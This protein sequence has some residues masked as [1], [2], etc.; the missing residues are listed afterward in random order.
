MDMADENLTSPLHAD[1]PMNTEDTINLQNQAPPKTLTGILFDMQRH[2]T[3]DGP[4]IRTTLFFKGCNLRCRWCHNPESFSMGPDLEL[5]PRRCI[6]CGLCLAQCPNGAISAPNPDPV[7]ERMPQ[8]D[9][10]RCLACGSCVNFC[11]AGARV[12]AGKRYGVE[13][14]MQVV[15][16]D[17]AFYVNSGGGVTCS[18]GEPLLQPAFLISILKALREAGIHTAVDTA[19][20]VPWDVFSRILPYSDLILYDVKTVDDSIHREATGVGNERIMDNLRRLCAA[21]MPLWVR[22]PVIPG[23]NASD[24]EMS[25]I[26]MFLKECG[27]AGKVELLPLHHLGSG[28]YESL[29]VQWPMSDVK[30]PTDEE[31]TR[32]RGLFE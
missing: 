13:E 17:R 29:G 1:N 30:T 19:G 18:G 16:Q 24:A 22:I 21:G 15:L 3:H 4:G 10:E 31:M 14:V 2:T 7:S 8:T 23:V 27:H 28:K 12:L 20:N 9:R 32:W 5:Y 11:F 26:A 6:E 25:A